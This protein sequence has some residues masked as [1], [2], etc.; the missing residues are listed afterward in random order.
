VAAV[1]KSTM[2]WFYG[3]KLHWVANDRGGLLGVKFTSANKDDRAQVPAMV[4]TLTGKSCGDKGYLSPQLGQVLLAQGLELVTSICKNMKPNLLILMDIILLRKRSI[5]E[6]MHDQLKHISQL[7]YSRYRSCHHFM[8][9]VVG[10]LMAYTHQ[11]KKPSINI[12][13]Q[14]DQAVA[15]MSACLSETQVFSPVNPKISS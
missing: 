9:N 3:F 12:D 15:I 2:G 13:R 4:D 7:E 14:H 5:I 6:T 11:E 1:G 10:A 8:V